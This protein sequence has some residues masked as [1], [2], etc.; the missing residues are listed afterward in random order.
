MVG[1]GQAVEMLEVEEHNLPGVLHQEM[2][3]LG[4]EQGRSAEGRRDGGREVTG[5][6]R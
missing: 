5:R 4:G 2:P 3:D 1:G 6:I